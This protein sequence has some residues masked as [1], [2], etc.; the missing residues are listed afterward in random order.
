[1]LLLQVLHNAC[2]RQWIEEQ[3]RLCELF[4]ACVSLKGNR[5][6]IYIF[7]LALLPR[8]FPPTH[9]P[10]FSILSTHLLD[11]ELR[12]CC[13]PDTVLGPP[14]VA[15]RLDIV[16]VPRAL[17]FTRG[18]RAAND[19]TDNV[20]TI[21]IGWDWLAKQPML[22]WDSES[23]FFFLDQNLVKMVRISFSAEGTTT[24]GALRW[25]E[26]WQCLF[27]TVICLEENN[28]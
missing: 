4:R 17:S 21:V 16:P 24:T 18:D 6:I 1:M 20:I 5:L 14:S 23:F 19:Y 27:K 8:L 28:K 2:F 13:M 9:L 25:E 12:A 10:S 3:V 11:I 26:A 22:F 15:S 7:P